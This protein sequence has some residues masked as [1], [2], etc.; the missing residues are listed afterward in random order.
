MSTY[1][2]KRASELFRSITRPSI[3]SILSYAWFIWK[4]NEGAPNP[5]TETF[6]REAKRMDIDTSVY[7]YNYIGRTSRDSILKKKEIWKVLI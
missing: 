3:Y 1:N 4:R 7:Y 2:S 5:Y 6:F